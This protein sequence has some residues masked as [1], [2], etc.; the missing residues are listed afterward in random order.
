[1]KQPAGNVVPG[2]EKLVHR[3]KKSLYG[4]KQSPRCWNRP[5]QDFL[6]DLGF[7]Q[8]TANPCVFNNSDVDSV[9]IIAIY[10]D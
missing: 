4:L 7:Q 6:L 1:M 2:K 10:V 5:V 8:S 3:L 9:T